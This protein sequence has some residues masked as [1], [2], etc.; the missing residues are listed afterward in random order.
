MKHFYA[1]T[2]LFFLASIGLNLKAQNVCYSFDDTILPTQYDQQEAFEL[3]GNGTGGFLTNWDVVCGTPSIIPS[4]QIDSLNAYDGTQYALLTVCNADTDFSES[5]SLKYNFAAGLFEYFVSLAAVNVP[6]VGG[7]VVPVNVQFILLKDSIP[8]T[9]NWNTGC[10][11]TP[12]VDTPDMVVYS[13]D[14]FSAS[15]WQIISFN[16]SNLSADYKQLWIRCSLANNVPLQTTFFCFDSMCLRFNKIVGISEVGLSNNCSLLQNNPNPFNTS[17]IIG[18]YLC[19][20][21]NAS[22]VVN[23]LMGRTVKTIPI[24]GQ[25]KGTIALSNS[26]LAAGTYLYSLLIDG[27]VFDTKRM[28]IEN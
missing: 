6:L 3:F 23:D 15:S 20:Q 27:R 14:S 28:V 1:V 7:T 25:G 12:P 24:A 22:I 11:A 10:T 26:Q 5:V 9:Y 18:Y 21:K 16:F 2:A 17:T 13:I 8:F 4:G 19:E